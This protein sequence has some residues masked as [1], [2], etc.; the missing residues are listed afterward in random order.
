MESLLSKEEREAILKEREDRLAR[1][2]KRGKIIVAV[3]SVAW[4]IFTII[5]IFVNFSI[6]ALIIN[7]S[8]AWALWFGIKW[9]RVYFAFTVVVGLISFLAILFRFELMVE[10]PAWGLAFII[11]QLVFGIISSILLFKDKGVIDF[12]E[13]QRE[14]PY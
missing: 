3:I 1:N 6:M 12:M 14:S 4:T 11:I 13:Y 7:I 5:S 8:A 9:I 2:Y 10:I